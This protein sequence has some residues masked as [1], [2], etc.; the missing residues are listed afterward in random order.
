MCHYVSAN[1]LAVSLS[2]LFQTEIVTIQGNSTFSVP[3][4]PIFK[5]GI[6]LQA[7]IIFTLRNP[8]SVMGQLFHL[9]WRV[10]D[11]SSLSVWI[12]SLV[13]EKY[14]HTELPRRALES[15]SNVNR[16]T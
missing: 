7:Q 9:R 16:L 14:K 13:S 5:S 10:V 11:F 1:V 12:P 15:R 4:L 8:T 6:E 2:G 3:Y